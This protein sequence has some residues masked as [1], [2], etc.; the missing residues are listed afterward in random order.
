MQ[1]I[2][3]KRK[4]LVVISD[5]HSGHQAGLTH[6]DY[7]YRRIREP[8]DDAERRR[9]KFAT[10][11][12]QIW[13]WFFSTIQQLQPVHVLFHLGDAIDGRGERSGG[14]EI[15]EADQNI[16]CTMA[17]RAIRVIGAQKIFMVYG[18][19]YHTCS[20]YNDWEDIVADNLRTEKIGSREFVDI[21]GTVF[22]LRHK[23]S[24][25]SIPHGQGTLLAKQKLWNDMWALVG[26]QPDA[27][28]LLRGH[29]HDFWAMQNTRWLAM[30]LPGLEWST[31]YGARIVDGMVNIGFVHFDVEPDGSFEWHHHDC[32]LGVLKTRPIKV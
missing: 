32:Q 9:N 25:S 6:P 31:K 10:L 30:A 29:I 4:R 17:T 11:Q 5:P 27:D 24:K 28:V 3:R 18:T 12:K 26:R 2:V 22:D 7:Q 21:N 13:E 23:M 15:I 14:T 16:Q 19:P 8:A 1:T 20:G